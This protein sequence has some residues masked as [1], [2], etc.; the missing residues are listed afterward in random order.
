MNHSQEMTVRDKMKLHGLSMLIPIFILGIVF[1]LQDV[2][3][4]GDRQ[5]L[6]SDFYQQYY[7]FISDYWHKIRQGNSLL[8]SWTAGG[9]HDYI[10]HFGFYLASP[11]NLLAALFPHYYLREVLTFF[12][13]IK[14][15][16]A[17]FFMSI[18]LRFT[19]KKDDIL[20]SAFSAFYGLCAF[21]LGFYTNIM[22]LD[23]FALMPLVMLGVYSLVQEGKYRLYIISLALAILFNFY[24]GFFVCIFTAILFFVQCYIS[25]LKMRK[26]LQRL[27]TIAVCSVIALG[28]SAVLTIPAY[29]ALQGSYRAVSYFPDFRVYRSFAHVLGNFIAFTP[30]TGVAVG[31]PNLYSGMISVMLVPIFLLSKEISV[32][33]K[34]AY[35]S[36]LIFLVL[37]V[38]INVLDFIWNAFTLTIGF[39]FRFSFIASFIVVAMAYKAYLLMDEIK[40]K[41]IVVMGLS[42]VFFLGMA[43]IGPQ[44][45]MHIIYSGI[46]S[47]VYLLL[48]AFIRC[49]DKKHVVKYVFL[50]VIMIELTFTAY[51]GVTAIGTT[52]RT[53]YS[54][55]YDQVQQLLEERQLSE[56]DFFRTELI[57]GMAVNDP[58][59]YGFNGITL[60]SSI[61]NIG[62][63]NFMLE[64][65]LPAVPS[66]NRFI[67]VETSPLTNAFLN[68]RYLITRDDYLVDDGIFWDH[69]ASSFNNH[70]FK[71]KHYLPFGFMVNEEILDYIGDSRNPFNSQ[72][73][74]FKRATGLDG[75]L[76][77]LIDI[78]HVGHRNYTVLRLG[79]GEYRF[80]INEGETNG[81]F[82]FNYEMPADGRLYAYFR[83]PNTNRV[84]VVTE[85]ETLHSFNVRWPHIFFAGNFEQEQL[86]SIEADSSS[87]SGTGRIFVSFLNQELLEQGLEILSAETLTLTQFSDTSFTG[88]ITVSEPRLLYTSLPHANNW[89]VFVNDVEEEIVT[90]GGAMAGVRLGTGTHIIEFR[91]H[92]RSLNLGA[93]ISFGSLS[94]Y[95]LLFW[96]HRKEVNIFEYF[97]DTEVQKTI[98]KK[99]IIKG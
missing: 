22:W 31:L 51:N 92:N 91:Y 27:A 32:R 76:F 9:G 20:L 28:M 52:D 68:M 98:K 90:I 40:V 57:G 45:A 49:F 11:F 85:G 82:R 95:V 61:T 38:N 37:S 13:L 53:T 39:P 79:L 5:I 21:T 62:V 26:F 89:R 65:G 25:K 30:P 63:T 86:V 33:E 84:R 12:V 75:D 59:L 1:A 81:L 10:T 23:T 94:I 48:F 88:T 56:L 83:I 70:L 36:M 8:W 16:F 96:L 19:I 74:L 3:P 93:F 18:F 67:Y 50:I 47:A 71:N 55:N 29:F 87:E 34:I 41:Y 80:E 73:D 46:L 72:N 69:V 15:G 66:R 2:Y 42:A 60:F 97:I 99:K 77:T 54:A 43:V 44:Y 4:F 78:I 24:I 6:I 64:L 58:Y 14:V 35:M 17:S 7:P